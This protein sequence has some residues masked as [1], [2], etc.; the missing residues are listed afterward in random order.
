MAGARVLIIGGRQSA[1]EWAALIREDGPRASSCCRE[2]DPQVVHT[3]AGSKRCGR[4]RGAD[5]GRSFTASPALL[6]RTLCDAQSSSTLYFKTTR[7]LTYQEN[8]TDC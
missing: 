8:L 7:S 5:R 4:R 6:R 2:R 3:A 1:Y